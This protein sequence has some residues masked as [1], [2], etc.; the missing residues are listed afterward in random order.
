MIY[1]FFATTCHHL[2][3]PSRALAPFAYRWYAAVA[4]RPGYGYED[5]FVSSAGAAAPHGNW[6]HVGP[7]FTNH[8]RVLAPTVPLQ[9]R[10][11]P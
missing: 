4:D 6:S 5:M 8:R 9:V 10:V 7:L 11:C 1:F 3:P 2:P